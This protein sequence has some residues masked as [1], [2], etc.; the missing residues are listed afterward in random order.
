MRDNSTV[1]QPTAAQFN[2]MM[3]ALAKSADEMFL[4]PRCRQAL[5]L[6]RFNGTGRQVEVFQAPGSE[7]MPG[8]IAHNRIQIDDSSFASSRRTLRLVNPLTAINTVYRNLNTQQV[9]SI[10]PRSEMEL[11]HL[12]GAGFWACNIQALD[13]ISTSPWIEPGDMHALPYP[14]DHFD[15]V[16]SGWVLAYSS[17]PQKAVN[18]MVR[19]AK[20][21][22][23]LAIANTFNPQASEVDYRDEDAKI[24][25]TV[26]RRVQQYRDLLGP[27]LD[28]VYF[29]DE[30][31]EERKDA[32]IMIA[33]IKR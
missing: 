13:L 26:F 27:H 29:Q 23:I 17:D 25:G 12:V 8:T 11:I 10:G 28:K 24:V 19:V 7:V 22:A 16:M 20:N 30:P 21:G 33:R 1:F 6:E 18:E 5:A 31:E 3:K 15:V 32:V 9:L 4:S 14:D 2:I